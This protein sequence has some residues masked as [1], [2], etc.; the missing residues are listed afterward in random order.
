MPGR[1]SC[2][3][4]RVE[5]PTPIISS[6]ERTKDWL[7]WA[8][9]IVA[10]LAAGV[11]LVVLWPEGDDEPAA[12]GGT[13]PTSASATTV[14]GATGEPSATTAGGPSSTDVPEELDLFAGG[15]LA[16]ALADLTIAAGSPTEVIELDVY[17]GYAFLAYRDPG[18]PDH[19]DR[20]V[21]RDREVGPPDPNPI[22]DRVD[23]DTAPQLFPITELDPGAI[24]RSIAATPQHFDLPVAVTHVIV[25]RF[26]PFDDRVLIRVYASPTDGRSGGGYVRYTTSGDLVAVTS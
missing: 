20:R 21:W 10:S 15:D 26:L 19:I 7:L 14:E 6:D 5:D 2:Y 8:L 17:P 22:D 13:A 3:T 25:D 24:E 11:A 23:A 16:G 9:G 18:T 12:S 4:R 1:A